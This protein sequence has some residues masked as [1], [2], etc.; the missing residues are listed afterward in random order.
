MGK[1]TM[2]VVN[3]LE[4]EY[5]GLYP[6]LTLS[7]AMLTYG[8]ADLVG[9][10]GFLAVYGAAMVLGN[11]DFLHKRSL[12]RFHD[13]L[14]WLMQI[15]MFLTLGLQVFPSQLPSIT[16][17]GLLIACT[18]MFIARP[19]AVML[20]LTGSALTRK[21]RIFV[22]WVGLRGAAPIVL[23]TFPLLAA[24]PQ[25][26]LI[27]NVVFFIVLTSSVLQGMSLGWVAERL[28]LIEHSAIPHVDPLDLVSNG[29]RDIV[30]L[31]LGPDAPASGRRI[32]DLSLPSST[33]VLV[34]E[35]GGNSVIPRSS[36]ELEAGDV[37][38]V[39]AAKEQMPA[40]RKAISG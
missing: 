28:G 34:V 22:A 17:P 12:I 29:E 8:L 9:G 35:R 4:L 24:I 3:R 6:V 18:L 30:E 39:L 32:V 15:A 37:V 33:L 1:V 25:A 19:A 23:A 10:N 26:G 36:T 14:A 11:S 7:L 21:Q 2:F 38:L 27:F 20:L 13:G 40:V 16:V 31:A 5:E